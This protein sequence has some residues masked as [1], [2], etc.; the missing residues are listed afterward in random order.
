MLEERGGRLPLP[1]SVRQL[2][3]SDEPAVTRVHHF[4]DAL[5]ALSLA[6]WLEM[7]QRL[8]GDEL[9]AA[10]RAAAWTALDAAIAERRLG[11]AVWH[12]RDAVETAAFL[13]TRRVPRMS[14]VERRAMVA[15]QGAAEEAAIA[16]LARE[17][18]RPA[19]YETLAA[20]FG[21]WI[22]VGVPAA[23]RT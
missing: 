6:A 4:V 17:H 1:A 12:V 5:C 9:G 22:P 21:A 11:V 13:A 3:E 10:A 7:G 16:L 19:D 8:L 18:V 2:E 20:P 23:D 15:A 14:R